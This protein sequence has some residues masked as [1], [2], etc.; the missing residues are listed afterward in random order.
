MTAGRGAF[1]RESEG[2]GLPDRDAR[3]ETCWL[4]GGEAAGVFWQVEDGIGSQEMEEG[5]GSSG[6]N[7]TYSRMHPPVLCTREE[8]RR[9]SVAGNS[10]KS[11]WATSPP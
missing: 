3:D 6:G 1:R 11:H 9:Q 10:M 4:A 5:R 2:D 7:G 8:G